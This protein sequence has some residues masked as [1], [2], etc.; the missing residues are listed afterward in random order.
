MGILNMA[1]YMFN[2]YMYEKCKER[3]GRDKNKNT[4]N[5]T[6]LCNMLLLE[7]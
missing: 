3:C 2:L 5:N 7:T 1:D 6:D 4:I